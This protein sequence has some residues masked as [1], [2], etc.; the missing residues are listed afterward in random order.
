MPRGGEHPSACRVQLSHD[1]RA[2][3]SL[4]ESMR[5]YQACRR[6]KGAIGPGARKPRKRKTKGLFF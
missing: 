4:S 2:G 3:K 1:R 6:L 5:N